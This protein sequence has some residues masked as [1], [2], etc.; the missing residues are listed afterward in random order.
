MH[1]SPQC[2]AMVLDGYVMKR[3][4]APSRRSTMAQ[5]SAYERTTTLSVALLPGLFFCQ[6][7]RGDFRAAEG[8]AWDQIPVKRRRIFTGHVLDG[9]YP[10]V[11][12]R[13]CQPVPADDVTRRVDALFRGAVE[14]VDPYLAPF[15]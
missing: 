10:L 8:D 4:A 13:V 9:D 2:T 5:N 12:G 15:V 7:E 3:M 14:L 6:T 11:P 1:P